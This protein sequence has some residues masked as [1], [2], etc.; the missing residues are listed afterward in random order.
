[1]DISTITDVN[2]LKAMAYDQLMLQNQATH[3]IQLIESRIVQVE[4]EKA[5]A[6][7]KEASESVAPADAPAPTTP[8]DQQG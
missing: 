3:N 2:Q 7:E 5:A 8:A 6:A 1:M 4:N